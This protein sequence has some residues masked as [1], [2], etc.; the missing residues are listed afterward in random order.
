MNKSTTSETEVCGAYVKCLE[1]IWDRFGLMAWLDVYRLLC[2]LR[3]YFPG[4]RLKSCL[5]TDLF[6][7]FWDMCALQSEEFARAREKDFKL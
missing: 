6:T 3:K 4:E 7:V 2:L 5:S 1:M